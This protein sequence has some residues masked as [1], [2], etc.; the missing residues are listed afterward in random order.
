MAPNLRPS[1]ISMAAITLLAERE[2][3]IVLGAN[4]SDPLSAACW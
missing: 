3:V 2:V 1:G 4:S